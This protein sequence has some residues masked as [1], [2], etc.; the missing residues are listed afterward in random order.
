VSTWTASP[1]DFPDFAL[2]FLGTASAPDD[3]LYMLGS[4]GTLG[5]LDVTTGHVTVIG[6]PSVASR[7]G[8]MT[9]NGDGT[10][11]FLAQAA[12]QTLNRLDPHN[13]SVVTVYPTHEDGLM[14]Q[15]LAYYGGLFFD[16][17][18]QDIYTFDTATGKTTAVGKAPL[19]VT[20]AGQS[21]CVPAVAPPPP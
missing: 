14:D 4:S 13:A 10:L 16:F 9:T 8:D 12:A 6:S 20:G 3:A 17:L 2:T 5:S 15:A 19:S 7:T 11:Y 1:T 18:G 21:T